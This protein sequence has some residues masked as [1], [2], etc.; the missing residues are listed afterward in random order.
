MSFAPAVAATNEGAERLAKNQR[1]HGE[2]DGPRRYLEFEQARRDRGSCQA[3]AGS[4]QEPEEPRGRCEIRSGV[5]SRGT[6]HRDRPTELL[7]HWRRTHGAHEE[8]DTPNHRERTEL[9]GPKGALRDRQ[10]HV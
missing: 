3:D 10:A 5:P 9:L 7:F 2:H 1:G 6:L 4:C 8:T